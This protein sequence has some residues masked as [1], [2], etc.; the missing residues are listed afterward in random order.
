MCVCKKTIK[1]NCQFGGQMEV[2]KIFEENYQFWRNVNDNDYTK[3]EWAASCIFDLATY[4]GGLDEFFVNKIF[5]VCNV[6]IEKRN[7]EY[8]KASRGNYITYILVVQLL[9]I[10]GWIDWGTSIRGAWIED[11]G[12]MFDSGIENGVVPFTIE[13]LKV[14]IEFVKEQ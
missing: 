8:I 13:N 4:D 7:F 6:L 10:K 3:H 5:E 2:R 1:I 12:T 14:L 11:G 9:E